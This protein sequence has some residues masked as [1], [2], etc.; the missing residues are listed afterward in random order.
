MNGEGT[1][2]TICLTVFILLLLICLC[3]SDDQLTSARPLSPGDLLI[4]KNGVF[5]LG[6]FS[7]VGSNESLYVGIWFHGIPEHNRTIV[8]VANRDNPTTTAST[9]TL[10]ISNSSDLVLSDSKGQTLWR[11]QNINAAHDSGAF[12]VLRDTGNLVLQLPNTSVIWQSFDHPTDTILPGME[13]LLIHRGRAVARLI[14][15]RSPDDPST[16]DFSFGLD[17]VSNLQLIIWNG[18]KIYCRISV[19]NGVLGGMYPSSPSSMVYQT[20]VNKGDEFYL[21][22]VVSGGSPYSRIMLDHTGTMKLLTWDSNSSSW[23]VISE[24]P[25][26]GYGLYDSCGPNGYCDFTEAAPACHC[27][28]GFEAVGLNSSR[29]CRR[30]EPLQCSK[31]SHFVAL[32]RMRVPDKFMLLRNRTF[33]QCAAECSRNCSCT[34]YAYANLSSGMADQSRCL[35]WTGELVDTWKSSNYGEVLYLRLANPPVKTKTNLVKIVVPVTA[36]LLLPICIALVCIY[37][38]KAGKWR[39][40]EIQ[41]KLMLGYLG[42]SNELGDKNVEFPFVSFDDIVAA[43]DNFSDCHMLGRGGFG[44]VYKGMLK[45]GKEVAVKRL[46]QGSGQGIDEFRNEVVLL[47]KLQHRNLVRLLGCCIHEEEKLLIYEYLPNKSLDAFLFDNSRKHVL[48]WP[49]RFKIVK[50]VAR[51]LLY[52]HQDSRL[53]I[54]HRDLKA[55]N[56]LLDTKMSPKISDF[57]MARIF[58]GNQQ[59]ANTTRVVGTYGYMSPEYVTSGAFSV[60]SDTYSF[61]V[62]LLEIAW[63]LW[64]DGNAMELVDS[65]VAE[66]CPAHE[67]LRCIHVGLLCVQDNPNARPLMSSVVFMLENETTLLPAPKE[68]VYFAPRNNE[69]EETRRNMEGSLNASII[70]TLEGR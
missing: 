39:K 7:P 45:G 49:T 11:T 68:P 47:V 5:A 9:P 43:T 23:T 42:T 2:G 18:A 55:S 24:R 57:G 21:E 20:I 34:A 65:S 6:F 14:S 17:P 46:S 54:I 69:T 8:W 13:F 56:I 40:E 50:G 27:L 16:G 38:F 62:L 61:G 26:G 15:W 1:M 12:L 30:T 32:P 60:K 3:Q 44:K 19:W 28:E 63:T 66:N 25:E 35:V 48:D 37:K 59:L 52:L 4:S 67:V 33:E 36:C 31:G 64:E 51:G 29:G 22:I 70:T 10:A 58:G 41:K 53:T